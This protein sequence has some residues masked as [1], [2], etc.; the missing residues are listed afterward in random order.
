MQNLVVIGLWLRSLIAIAKADLIGSM[1]PAPAFLTRFSGFNAISLIYW[2]GGGYTGIRVHQA[3]SQL[4][5]FTCCVLINISIL[6]IINLYGIFA[7]N[8]RSGLAYSIFYGRAFL[9][10]ALSRQ[11]DDLRSKVAW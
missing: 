8:V 11:L 4:C 1:P 7:F 5:D 6:R 3:S 2:P 9:G 10:V